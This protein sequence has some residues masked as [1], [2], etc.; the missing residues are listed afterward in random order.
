MPGKKSGAA[1][2]QA[3]RAMFTWNNYPVHWVKI[4]EDYYKEGRVQYI[5]GGAETAPTTGTPHIQGY[6][7]W[8][9]KTKFAGLAKKW[10]CAFLPANGSDSDN[11]A[12][13]SKTR[14]G[15]VPNEIFMEW[16]EMKMDPKDRAQFGQLGGDMEIERWDMAREAAKRGDMESIP[17]DLYIRYCKNFE[18]IRAQNEPV[19]EDLDGE[20]KHMWIHG[21]AGVG[22]SRIA[23]MIGANS[24]YIK[25]LN[26]WWDGYKGQPFVVLDELSTKNAEW[27]GDMLKIWA[28]RYAFNSETKG[29]SKVIR[30][31]CIIVTSNY[32]I[33]D[34]WSPA[35]D[36]ALCE[37]ITRRFHQIEMLKFGDNAWTKELLQEFADKLVEKYS[38]G[39]FRK[40]KVTSIP[41][42][43]EFNEE[44]PMEKP[45][46]E[47][48][49]LDY[50]LNL[51]AF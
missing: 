37:A 46:E 42:V 50:Y 4:L 31:L 13:C 9:D 33:K 28:D 20:L 21:P 25:N 34:L 18:W 49:E 1:P 22:K 48:S 30:P 40:I 2:S 38:L 32:S 23:R 11:R 24:F 44:F 19:P 51:D 43:E 29:S 12:Y 15:D 8:K 27:M 10:K 14:I 39:E 35:V 26:K 41:T 17:S 47:D 45:V 7:S 36:L 5:C 16:G 3:R 6:I